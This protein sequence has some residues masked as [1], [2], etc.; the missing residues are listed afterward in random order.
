MKVSETKQDFQGKGGFRFEVAFHVK[1]L[2]KEGIY[3]RRYPPQLKSY[4]IY[5]N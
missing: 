3:S 2:R 4:V 1:R 5:L